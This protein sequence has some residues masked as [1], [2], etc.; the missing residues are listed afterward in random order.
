MKA[1]YVKENNTMKHFIFGINE[2]NN[3]IDSEEY[4][5]NSIEI[6]GN[7]AFQ[8]P[9]NIKRLFFDEKLMI[10]EKDAFKDC[11]ELEVFCCGK[12]S[13]SEADAI[14]NLEVNKLGI[15][16]NS[17]NEND[18]VKTDFIVQTLAFSGCENLHTIVFPE[19]SKL[20]IE[21]YAFKNCS[22][23]R[24]VITFADEIFFTENPFDDCPKELT[25]ICKNDNTQ[26]ARFARENGY[27]VINV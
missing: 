18:E 6:V 2:K 10:I 1:V 21:K 25:F 13:E 20:I 3:G 26:I 4:Q 16:K 15:R 8:N 27:G 5:F 17:T 22:S 14:M 12:I 24:T 11:S 9:W 23:L 7:K 19:C